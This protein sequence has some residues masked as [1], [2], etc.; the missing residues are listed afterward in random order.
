MKPTVVR[1]SQFGSDCFAVVVTYGGNG[2]LQSYKQLNGRTVMINEWC[3]SELWAIKQF[4]Q[5]LYL[6]TDDD[7]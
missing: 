5:S 2:A 6:E 3:G 1:F 4:D 7:I